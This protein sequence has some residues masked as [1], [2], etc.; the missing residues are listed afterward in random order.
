MH[1][2]NEQIILWQPS[3]IIFKNHQKCDTCNKIHYYK[4]DIEYCNIIKLLQSL[5]LN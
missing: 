1:D 3:Y 5:K 4:L 2:I